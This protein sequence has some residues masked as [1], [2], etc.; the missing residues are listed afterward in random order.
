MTGFDMPITHGQR[1][2]ACYGRRRSPLTLPVLSALWFFLSMVCLSTG[3]AKIYIDVT[4]PQSRRLP[5]AI[6]DFVGH[7]SGAEISEIVRSDINTTGL[8]SFADREAHFESPS[9]R[10]NPD[11]WKPLGIEIVVKGTLEVGEKIFVTL[12]LY[13]AI[14]GR[15]VLKKRFSAR[16]SH[17]RPLSHEIANGIYE[18]ITGLK[19]VFNTK[20]AFVSQGE[21][22]KVLHIMDWD[23]QRVRNILRARRGDLI[24][25][26]HWSPDGKKLAYSSARGRRWGIY[27]IDFT[28]M[29]EHLIY[30]SQGTN[31]AGDF[32]PHGTSLMLSSSKKGSPDLYLLDIKTKVLS[33]LT[34]TDG[35]EISPSVSPDGQE[36]VFVSD[37]SGSPQLYSMRMGGNALRRVTFEGSYNT[38]PDW[39]QSGEK[40][41][42]SGRIGGKNQIFT[43]NPDGTDL[44]Q[45]TS[46]GNNEDPAFSPDGRFIAFTSDRDG[47]KGIF[48]MRSNGEG[49]RRISPKN[50]RAFGPSW[51]PK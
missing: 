49:Q 43:V 27:M 38:S 26:P 41:A 18:K 37:R 9:E 17:L 6:Q 29:K 33:R 10:F 36:V 4:S 42:L 46:N 23:G 30:S 35:I 16:K 44:T 20:I 8:F 5:I 32:I 12:S 34:Y 47:K 14:E 21:G 28:T 40:I 22:R 51:S 45:L 19:G 24:M 1:E 15:E 3:E 25:P 31:I 13:D 11:N 48:V 50:L 39:S 2:R 7:P